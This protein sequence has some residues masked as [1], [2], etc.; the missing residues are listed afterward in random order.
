[1][2][3]D[4][5]GWIAFAI[6]SIGMPLGAFAVWVYQGHSI[7]AITII[8]PLETIPALIKGF[9]LACL[10]P[11]AIFGLAVSAGW[12]EIVNSN[13][14]I[15]LL[16]TS[17]IVPQIAVAV[18]EELAFRGVTQPLL[19]AQMGARRALAVTSLLFGLFHLPNIFYSD[20]PA[21]LIPLTVGALT[22]MG[23]VFGD[24]FL[25]TG[26]A[27]ALPIAL[28]LSWNIASFGIDPLFDYRYAGSQWIIGVPEWFPESGILGSIGLVVL[29]VLIAR[30]VG[31]KTRSS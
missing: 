16:V 21:A 11:C 19:A 6:Y 2:L 14:N 13:L 8:P 26:N 20:I 18:V 29:G 3:V 15:A 9:V 27:V 30:I 5:W 31:P 4:S 22:I 1:M 12:I 10:I 24:A 7:R 23:W 17:I 25:R 28:H